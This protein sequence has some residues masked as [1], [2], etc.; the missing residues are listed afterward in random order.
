MKGTVQEILVEGFSKKQVNENQGR[1]SDAVQWTG[2]T[3]GNKIANFVQNNGSCAD[4][5][6]EVGEMVR[7]KIEKT[8]P[9]SLWGSVVTCD[10]G[11]SLAKGEE[12]YAA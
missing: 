2:R 10:S 5:R 8:F 11:H 1:A 3:T 6:V 4:T 12:S 9:H 7:V